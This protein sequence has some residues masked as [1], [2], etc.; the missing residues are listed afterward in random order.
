MGYS[1]RPGRLGHIIKTYW[2]DDDEDN[3][4]IQSGGT[5]EDIIATAISHFG[6]IEGLKFEAE[7]VHTDCLSYDLYDPNDYTNFIHIYRN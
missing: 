5:G 4:W 1:T 6:S 2:P 3:L 7:Y